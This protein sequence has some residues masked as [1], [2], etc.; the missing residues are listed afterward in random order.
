M[1]DFSFYNY[2]LD[3]WCFNAD[4]TPVKNKPPVFITLDGTFD[5]AKYDKWLES[6]KKK[7]LTFS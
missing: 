4:M 6:I 3:N 7:Y 1:E 5:T 2:Y